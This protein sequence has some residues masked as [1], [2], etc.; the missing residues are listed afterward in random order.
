MPPK[1]NEAELRKTVLWETVTGLGTS[2]PAGLGVGALFFGWAMGSGNW[3]IA[4]ILGIAGGTCIAL[5]RLFSKGEELV[6]AAFKKIEAD[7]LRRRKF[8]LDSFSD[9]LKK[10]KDQSG[11]KLLALFEDMRQLVDDFLKDI[12]EGDL[13]PKYNIVEQIEAAYDA[14]VNQ[15]NLVLELREQANKIK[16]EK[17]KASIVARRDK[18]VGQVEKSVEQIVAAVDEVRRIAASSSTGDLESAYSELAET[19]EFSRE[20]DSELNRDEYAEF[21]QF[22]E[23]SEEKG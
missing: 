16:T 9:R 17:T 21:R 18:L 2:L 4:G 13:A 14:T 7:W 23:K 3:I 12:R 6:D 19:L 8:E 22:V 5:T 20:V 1:F 10:E 15:I 11:K